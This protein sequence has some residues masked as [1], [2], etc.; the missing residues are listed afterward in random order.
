MCVFFILRNADGGSGDGGAAKRAMNY[1]KM[2]PVRPHPPLYR[3]INN[4]NEIAGP[5]GTLNKY[6]SLIIKKA[7][8][9]TQQPPQQRY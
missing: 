8:A 5:I 2:A 6:S 4:D 7:N 9:Q 3:V 1:K